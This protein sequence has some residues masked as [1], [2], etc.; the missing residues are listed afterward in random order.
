MRKSTYVQLQNKLS[1]FF[2]STQKFREFQVDQRT[3]LLR[4]HGWNK[5]FSFQVY[6]KTFMNLLDVSN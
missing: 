2:Q 3:S 5:W 4:I 1:K 6:I